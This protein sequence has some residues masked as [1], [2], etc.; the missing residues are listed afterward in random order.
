MT[1]SIKMPFVVSGYV[2]KHDPGSVLLVLDYESKKKVSGLKSSFCRIDIKKCLIDDVL[3][4]RNGLL[5]SNVKCTVSPRY[6]E[7]TSP[8]GDKSSG[9]RLIAS[10]IIHNTNHHGHAS[11]PA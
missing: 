7:F 9:T 1:I 8:N 11:D 4:V 2:Y 3:I 6:Y 10:K 5:G